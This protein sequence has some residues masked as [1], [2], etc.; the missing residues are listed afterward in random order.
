MMSIRALCL[1][2][3]VVLFEAHVPLLGVWIPVLILGVTALPW[4]AVVMA[5]DRTRRGDYRTMRRPVEPAQSA[6]AAPRAPDES[7]EPRVIDVDLNSD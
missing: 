5:N 1:I 3:I 2:L 6:L 4:L 7:D